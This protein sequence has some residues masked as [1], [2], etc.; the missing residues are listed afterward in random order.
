MPDSRNLCQGDDGAH[1][2]EQLQEQLPERNVDAG[3]EIYDHFADSEGNSMSDDSNSDGHESC[4]WE[5]ASGED[6]SD[7]SDEQDLLDFDVMYGSGP[8]DEDED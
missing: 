8:Y 7:F 2:L 4:R 6:A 3:P 5:D 1:D